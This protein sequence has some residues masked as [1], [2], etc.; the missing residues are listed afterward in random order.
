MGKHNLQS[1]TYEWNLQLEFLV[2]SF[3]LTKPALMCSYAGEL[4]TFYDMQT[5]NTF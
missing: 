3:P 5:E 2:F 1:D 4:K